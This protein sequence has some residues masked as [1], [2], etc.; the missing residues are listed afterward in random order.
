MN[1]IKISAVV[2]THNRKEHFGNAVRSLINQNINESK[3]EVIIIDNAS[4]DNTWETLEREFGDMPNV[5]CLFEP[6]LGLSRARNR[7]WSNASGQ[8]IA[9]LDDDA[10]PCKDWLKNLCTALDDPE[11]GAAGGPIFPLYETDVPKWFNESL[12][13]LY[14]CRD[15]GKYICDL[16]PGQFFYGTNMAIKRSILEQ[17][18]GFRSDLGRRG[19]VLLSDEELAVFKEIEERGYK[20]RYMPECIV[21]HVIGE[22]RLNMKWLMR[23]FYWLGRGGGIR[24]SDFEGNMNPSAMKRWMRRTTRDLLQPR[25]RASYYTRLIPFVA[26]VGYL[27]SVL[28]GKRTGM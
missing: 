16:I 17:V 25:Y 26:F 27:A 20:K 23:R 8:Y 18:G 13:P 3:Y 6:V 5:R 28:A 2:C 11:V 24:D 14:S 7:G 22:E 4:T 1:D 21:Y 15:W 19:S 9:F 10:L 12:L